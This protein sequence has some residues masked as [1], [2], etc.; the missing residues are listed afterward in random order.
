MIEKFVEI[1][2]EDPLPYTL[3]APESLIA[4][5]TEDKDCMVLH[6]TNWT[7]N[8]F[9]KPWKNEYY[10]APVEN[11]R[12][13][14]RI[15]KEKKVMRVTTLVHADFEKKISEQNLEVFFPRIESYQAVVV[16]FE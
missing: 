15:P 11:V 2:T 1:V 7:G 6:L 16:E 4:N 8:K 12:V 13:Q 9:E 3:D 14:I 5:L 10:L